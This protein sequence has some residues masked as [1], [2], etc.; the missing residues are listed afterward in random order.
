M[1]YMAINFKEKF[2]KINEYYRPKIIAQLNEYH[3][4]IAKIKGEFIW[5]SHPE[6]DE[7][8]IIMDGE[9]DIE[10]RDGSVNLRKGEMYIVPKGVEHK[11]SAKTE[12]SLLM[13]EPAGTLNTGNAGGE[14]TVE[15]P[16]WI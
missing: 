1:G 15:S 4:K 7:A 8:F 10:F 6:T 13:V 16:E 3:F 12:C 2:D 14:R 5:H 11:P 9:L